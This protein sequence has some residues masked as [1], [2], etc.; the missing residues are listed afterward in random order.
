MQMKRGALMVNVGRGS[1]VDEGAVATALGRGRLGGYAADVFEK[2]DWARP[3]RP[4]GIAPSLIADG[5]RTVF[6]PH[7]GSAVARVRWEMEFMAAL[8]VVAV[9][10]GRP[11]P[12]AFNR[13]ALGGASLRRLFRGFARC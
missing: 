7:L 1:V 9:L 6:T 4:A 5:A 2:E 11:P 3:D 13:P 12:N 8:D 10:Q